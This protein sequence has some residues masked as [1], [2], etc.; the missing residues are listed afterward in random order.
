LVYFDRI[1][2]GPRR[3]FVRRIFLDVILD[4]YGIAQRGKYENCDEQRTN[5][6]VFT[7]TI[8]TLFTILNSWPLDQVSSRGVKLSVQVFSPSDLSQASA[9]EKRMRRRQYGEKD[10]H[11]ARFDQS[12]P[13]FVDSNGGLTLKDEEVQLLEV[14][15]VTE[16]DLNAGTRDWTFGDL[17]R[18]WATACSAIIA[19][20]PRLQ[21]FSTNLHDGDKRNNVGRVFARNCKN[22]IPRTIPYFTFYHY[23]LQ[24]A[25]L[26][27]NTHLKRSQK[28]SCPGH[29]HSSISI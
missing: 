29:H 5:K 26:L 21:T 14:Q 28:V 13:G 27:K 3:A 18:I 19:K 1:V 4:S 10:F 12:F 2:R 7:H 24:K 20:L 23:Q 25:L 15:V 9:Q 17:R 6:W 8:Q 16:L 11:D 22:L